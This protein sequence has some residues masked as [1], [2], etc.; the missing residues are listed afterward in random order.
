M[1]FLQSAKKEKH[2]LARIVRSIQLA[3]E[4][5]FSLL[6]KILETYYVY[7]YMYASHARIKESSLFTQ[8]I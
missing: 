7:T 2:F 1:F 6:S 3:L 5:V 4:F 8:Y